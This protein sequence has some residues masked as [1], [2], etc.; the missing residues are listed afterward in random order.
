MRHW[1]GVLALVAALTTP[2]LI[3]AR[4]SDALEPGV[5]PDTAFD[6]LPTDVT[7]YDPD[8]MRVVGH[9]R[10]RIDRPDGMEIVEGENE[11]FDGRHDRER[12]RLKVGAPGEAPILLDAEHSFFGADGSPLLADRLDASAGTASCAVYVHGTAQ[13][14]R[15]TVVAPADTYAGATQL[16]LIVARLRQGE[17]ERIKLHAFNCLP[18]PKIM[19]IEASVTTTRTRWTMYPGVLATIELKPDLG[20][21]GVL[22]APFLPKMQA[23]FDPLDDWNYVGAAFDRFYKGEHILM[24]RT[25]RTS[26]PAE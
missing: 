18:G 10:Y 8:D 25:R 6:F 11:Y 1:L 12:E 16:M 3:G 14:H 2:V 4:S 20:W 13:V 17:R 23:W 7:I 21:L 9:G 19:A 22:V 5:D 24:V 15:S 26:A